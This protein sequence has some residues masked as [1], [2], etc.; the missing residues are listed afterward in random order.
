MRPL[1][2]PSFFFG[3]ALTS[4]DDLLA[5]EREHWIYETDGELFFLSSIQRSHSL[6][7]LYRLFVSRHIDW[8]LVHPIRGLS[9]GRLED[10]S[11]P[12]QSEEIFG[13]FPGC[14]QHGY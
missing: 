10:L 13:L 2:K 6:G 3:D 5:T 8:E 7:Y 1:K 12:P 11:M 9:V 4:D 14:A